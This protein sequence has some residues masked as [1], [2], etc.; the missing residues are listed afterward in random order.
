[1]LACMSTHPSTHPPTPTATPPQ[2]QPAPPGTPWH[3]PALD[4]VAQ[5]LRP[6]GVEGAQAA[7][8]LDVAHHAHHDHGGGLDDGHGLAGLLLVQLGAG[9]VH[10]AQD[11][12]AACVQRECSTHTA[13]SER[14]AAGISEGCTQPRASCVCSRR[15]G[16][17]ERA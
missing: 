2:P 13:V 5:V 4:L 10:V 6:H 3:P 16:E 17:G 8:G 1:M 15:E 12:G 7:R 11:V 9:L 14:R